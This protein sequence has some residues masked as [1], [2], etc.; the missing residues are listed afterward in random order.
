MTRPSSRGLAVSVAALALLVATGVAAAQ[1]PTVTTDTLPA[2]T[3]PADTSAP[4][5]LTVT[6]TETTT[7]TATETETAASTSR[8]DLE[9]WHWALL[10]AGATAV[11]LIAFAVGRGSRRQRREP[12]E[13][14]PEAR[15]QMLLAAL[16]GWIAEGWTIESQSSAE[17][18]VRKGTERRLLTVDVHGALNRSELPAVEADP[19]WIAPGSTENAGSEGEPPADEPPPDDSEG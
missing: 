4:D 5:G 3:L 12:V 1:D 8:V 7:E 15:N 2:E 17:A 11:V 13:K 9:S 6:V 18:V 10:A 16:S 14:S 19:T